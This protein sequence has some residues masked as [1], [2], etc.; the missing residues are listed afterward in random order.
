[1][2][3]L[4]E[5]QMDVQM[6]QMQHGDVKH[7]QC[8]EVWG[9][10]RA[11]DSGVIMPG[12]DAWIYS[13]PCR[14][15][16]AGGDVH[17]VSTCAGGL[18]VRLVLADIAGHGEG[19]AEMGSQLR[20]MMRRFINRHEQSN[21][22]QSL[23][24]EFTAASANGVFATAVV[25]TFE[26]GKNT[27][28]VSNAGHPAPLWYQAK[29]R[30]W[31]LLEPGT[32]AEAKGI[33]WGIVEESPY[34]Q[35]E[36]PMGVGDIVL[37]YTDSLAE[38]KGTDGEMLGPT[39]LLKIMSG[40]GNVTPSQLIPRLLAQIAEHDAEYGARDDVTCLAFRANG[41]RQSLPVRD[42]V[43]APFRWMLASAGVKFGYAGWKREAWDA[44]IES[45]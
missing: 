12:M 13:R 18:L 41:F 7:M 22:V 3:L 39:G 37:S 15:Q 9:G 21:V 44:P 4:R 35:F 31:A 40:L 23:N 36:S 38:A 19:V 6:D 1:M 5:G 20:V 25:M 43:F 17:F 8:M 14:D 45:M 30:R 33:P 2:A 42:M 26:C 16:E 32:A 28:K 27:L 11:I 10:N 34:H 29:R 24:R